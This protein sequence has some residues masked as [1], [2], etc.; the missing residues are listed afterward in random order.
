MIFDPTS[1]YG[2]MMM[3]WKE[4]DDTPD[5]QAFEAMKT[6]VDA[7]SNLSVR[8][9]STMPGRQVARTDLTQPSPSPFSAGTRARSS[10]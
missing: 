3:T 8:S 6:A 10:A 1:G 2:L 4:G 7:G 9:P 5:E